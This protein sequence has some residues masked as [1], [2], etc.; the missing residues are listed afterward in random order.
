[1]YI[2]LFFISIFLLTTACN[3]NIKTK[4]KNM[5]L[6]FPTKYTE[7]L[8]TKMKTTY[9]KCNDDSQPD[10]VLH[11]YIKIPNNIKPNSLTEKNIRG[12]NKIK[13]VASYQTIDES[14]YIEIQVV[15]E[16]LSH[17]INP[18]D[19][20]YA[21]LKNNGE[22]LISK[23]EIKGNAGI[24]LDALTSKEYPNGEMVISR[25]T[26]QK[27]YDPSTKTAVIVS[28]KVSCSV[29]DY[30]KLAEEIMAIALG[31]NFINKSNYQ[32]GEDLKRYDTQKKNELSFYFPS[33]W[34]GGKFVPKGNVPDRF[35]IFNKNENDEIQGAINL[36][37]SKENKENLFD[38]VTKRF[39]SKDIS[40]DLDELKE[41]QII[42]DNDYYDKKWDTE[43]SINDANN[44]YNGTIRISIVK[45]KDEYVLLELVGPNKN[46]DYF[47]SARNNR[48]FD[49]VL[50][51][52]QTSEKIE[53][54]SEN[55]IAINEKD[56]KDKGFFKR[57][58]G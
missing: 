13:E 22:T 48:A 40:I 39:S 21:L 10:S 43:G 41:T 27:N 49:L 18:S 46:Q 36:F 1:M 4:E 30:P 23:N 3:M 37:V 6:E 54:S 42:S 44:K 8:N 11:Y 14:P 7:E 25:S 26:A 45:T 24:Y 32:L 52:L 53:R 17:E 50:Q 12:S 29:K 47:N 15:Y 9:W 57:L 35:A 55:E 5:D 51:T 31:W 58:F 16:K 20:L 33:S 38:V 28:V 2:K 34:K 19:W 56:E